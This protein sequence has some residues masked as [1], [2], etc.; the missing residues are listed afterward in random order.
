MTRHVLDEIVAR[1]RARLAEA[2]EPDAAERATPRWSGSIVERLRRANGAPLRLIAEIKRRSPSA[3][4]LSTALSPA[5]R[6]AIYA[7]EGAAAISVLTDEDFFD[8][9]FTHLA[10]V[11]AGVDAPALCKDFVLATSQLDAAKA[12]GAAMVLL[13]VRLLDDAALRDLVAHARALGVEPFVEVTSDDELSRALSAGA[14]I[15]GVNARD[16]DTLVVDRARAAQLL[17]QIPPRCVAVHLSGLSSPRDLAELSPRADAALLGEALMRED[18][19]TSLLRE[20]V[21]AAGGPWRA[22]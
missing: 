17:A 14:S 5:E 7:R 9:S 6:A 22:A 3:G 20:L 4:A 1:K 11:A 10:S 13:I 8:G 21:A 19:P 16:L 15:V 12:A 2:R 18:D